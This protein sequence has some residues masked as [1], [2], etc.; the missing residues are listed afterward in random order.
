MSNEDG[1]NDNIEIEMGELGIANVVE[2][3]AKVFSSDILSEGI[4]GSLAL[5]AWFKYDGCSVRFDRKISF[6]PGDCQ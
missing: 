3:D 6:L 2:N 1:E 5:S 4:P